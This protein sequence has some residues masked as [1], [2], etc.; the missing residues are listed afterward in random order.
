MTFRLFLISLFAFASLS[1][2]LNAAELRT[3]QCVAD[4]FEDTPDAELD[5][6]EIEAQELAFQTYQIEM[7]A[8]RNENGSFKN[9]TIQFPPGPR[10]DETKEIDCRAMAEQAY[11]T[12]VRN[13]CDINR[14]GLIS[15]LTDG[16]DVRETFDMYDRL[17]EI[18]QGLP[19]GEDAHPF[20]GK[21]GM[22][23]EEN[24]A[25]PGKS[26][27][28]GAIYKAISCNIISS[29]ASMVPGGGFV[30]NQLINSMVPEEQLPN[31]RE[32]VDTQNSCLTQVV[33]GAI[34]NVFTNIQGLYDLGK[35]AVQGIVNGAKYVGGKIRDGWNWLVG[36][37]RAIDAEADQHAVAS[38][39]ENDIQNNEEA[40]KATGNWAQRLVRGLLD[41]AGDGMRNQFSCSKWAGGVSGGGV[42]GGLLNRASSSFGGSARCIE[43]APSWECASAKQ[44]VQ[45][46]CGVAGFIGGEVVTT[47]LTGGAVRGLSLAG[48]GVAS[49]AA[50][51]SRVA[52]VALA[53]GKGTGGLARGV[54]SR[55]GNGAVALVKTAG[56]RAANAGG[57]A[58][59]VGDRILPMNQRLQ[60]MYMQQQLKRAGP[61]VSASANAVK[62]VGSAVTW[63]VRKY[64][65]VLDR[66]YMLG[67]Y[68][69]DGAFALKNLSKATSADEVTEALE[70]GMRSRNLHRRDMLPDE[71]TFRASQ[72]GGQAHNDLVVA[73][74]TLQEAQQAF[75]DAVKAARKGANGPNAQNLMDE[76]D[77]AFL[78][79]KNAKNTLG[80]LDE[81]YS[82]ALTQHQARLAEE[83]RLAQE[84]AEREA[85]ELAERQAREAANQTSPSTQLTTTNS[86][87]RNVV[88]TR[89]NNGA[90]SSLQRRTG[91]TTSGSSSRTTAA[92]TDGTRPTTDDI[93]RGNIEYTIQQKQGMMDGMINNLNYEN[94]RISIYRR[95]RDTWDDNIFN[96][97]VEGNKLVGNR[98]QSNGELVEIDLEDVVMADVRGTFN[99][100]A[101]SM[102]FSLSRSTDPKYT[103][104]VERASDAT[105]RNSQEIRDILDEMTPMTQAERTRIASVTTYKLSNGIMP[106]E[107]EFLAS[108]KNSGG[109]ATKNGLPNLEKFREI[110]SAGTTDE[111]LRLL[112]DLY[113]GTNSEATQLIRNKVAMMSRRMGALRDSRLLVTSTVVASETNSALIEANGRN[114]P[115]LRA[116]NTGTDL[117]PVRPGSTAITRV[118]D[119]S[120]AIVVRQ[121]DEIIPPPSTNIVA[122]NA[123][124]FIVPPVLTRTNGGR[125]VAAV[126]VAGMAASVIDDNVNGGS[127][128]GRSSGNVPVPPPISGSRSQ[129]EYAL[130]ATIDGEPVACTVA[131]QKKI[132]SADFA[133]M[134]SAQITEE[135]ITLKWYKAPEY[136]AENEICGS[137]SSCVFPEDVE[138]LSVVAIKNGER[139]ATTGCSKTPIVVTAD[140][141]PADEEGGTP[142][143]LP[144]E[145][146]DGVDRAEEFYQQ[147]RHPAPSMFQPIRIPSRSTQYM[148]TGYF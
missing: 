140:R 66:A 68:G 119:A 70:S 114:I 40:Q 133:N 81:A 71:D 135:V 109:Y 79:Y 3:T 35:L 37:D 110:Y 87:S 8:C 97:R 56:T 32:C 33:W 95:G 121:G 50:N 12:S 78:A 99:G 107:I 41:A 138:T 65:D 64:L 136:S 124:E 132:G 130:N 143:D 5:E 23:L 58:L 17:E 84:A 144:R 30:A 63:P 91:N 55:M 141:D 39:V 139:I 18:D 15:C 147:Q 127:Q 16:W 101:F 145:E 137:A 36:N 26:E 85:R 7:N 92:L 125:I 115:L 106:T 29:V 82:R 46:V 134:T 49:A 88:Q 43:A 1:L 4:S 75:L 116:S 21:L 90:G 129:I 54:L 31:A 112:D 89:P 69:N 126:S 80:P 142:Y 51:G 62:T 86:G 108:I 11:M 22:K 128:S 9:D 120:T 122:R 148:G 73:Q 44:K 94:K 98:G 28:E 93:F 103:S 19:E 102:P 83:A 53:V 10:T 34:Q 6:A 117:I 146:G 25:C 13:N 96:P 131:L 113:R 42:A 76:A 74:E 2:Q 67:R 61:M 47:L 77:A 60:L 123:D 38:R 111:A 118:D 48:R 105:P 100:E 14:Q 27:P 72:A 59:K 57:M 45:M 24:F 104:W 52:R 20:A